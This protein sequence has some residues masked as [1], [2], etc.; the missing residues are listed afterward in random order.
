MLQQG[1]VVGESMLV[2]SRV[3]GSNSSANLLLD[4]LLM[5]RSQGYDRPSFSFLH[6]VFA[7]QMLDHPLR[8]DT[9]GMVLVPVV[10]QTKM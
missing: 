7:V 3:L 1:A 6:Y 2:S 4:L 10:V 9:P 5:L 8:P